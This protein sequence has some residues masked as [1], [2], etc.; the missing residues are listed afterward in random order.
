ML[1]IIA[2]EASAVTGGRDAFQ[3]LAVPAAMGMPPRSFAA[4]AW[5][6]RSLARSCRHPTRPPAPRPATAR[7]RVTRPSSAHTGRIAAAHGAR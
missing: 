7:M 1:N 2:P 6:A 3:R 5:S 4:Q